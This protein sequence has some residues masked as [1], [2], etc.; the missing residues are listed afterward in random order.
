MRLQS[1]VK[2]WET[3]KGRSKE[4]GKE[5]GMCARRGGKGRSIVMKRERTV[6]DGQDTTPDS[7]APVGHTMSWN[8]GLSLCPTVVD[9]CQ[10]QQPNVGD[11]CDSGGR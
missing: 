4:K 9:A 11:C 7:N 1:L 3:V 5:G 2:R 6:A 10:Q 8:V